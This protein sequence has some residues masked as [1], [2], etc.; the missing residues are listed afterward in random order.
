MHEKQ[1]LA[2]SVEWRRNGYKNGEHPR[3]KRYETPHSERFR[4]GA[5]ES[6]PA[7]YIDEAGNAKGARD[8]SGDI[9]IG[10]EVQPR[11]LH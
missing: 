4:T 3:Q 10:K 7:S 11:V 2:V 6:E 5:P 1:R 8:R 9:P